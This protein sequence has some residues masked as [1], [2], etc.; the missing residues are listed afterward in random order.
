MEHLVHTAAPVPCKVEHDMA[1]AR[2]SDLRYQLIGTFDGC[3]ELVS[4]QL[5]SGYRAMVTN[6]KAPKSK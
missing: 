2:V 3:H 1:V 4:R 6:T 5:D